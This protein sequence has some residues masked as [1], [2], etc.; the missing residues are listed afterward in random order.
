MEK[1]PP[2]VFVGICALSLAISAGITATVIIIQSGKQ[3]PA[4]VVKAPPEHK[5][6]YST[7]YR[8]NKE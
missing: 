2:F 5:P 1:I 8:L 4:P 3:P 6:T 7:V